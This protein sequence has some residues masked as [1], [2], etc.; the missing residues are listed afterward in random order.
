MQMQA[1]LELIDECRTRMFRYKRDANIWPVYHYHPEYDLLLFPKNTGQFILGDCIETVEP[2]SVIVNGPHLPHAF[3]AFEPDENDDERPACV[4]LQF[5]TKSLGQSFLD[6]EEMASTRVF[7]ERAR[8]GMKYTGEP[9]ERVAELMMEFEDLNDAQRLAQLLTIFD[10]LAHAPAADCRSLVSPGYSVGLT[11]R[12]VGKIDIVTRYIHE[13]L[14][15]PIQ[16]E[17]VAALVHMSAAS[18]SRFFKRHTGRT[19]VQYLNEMRIGA[20]CREL[21]NTDKSVTEV[22]FDSGFSTLSNFNRRFRDIK[23]S[24]PSRFRQTYRKLR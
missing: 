20:A 4:V 6:R 13:N 12:S 3:H 16:Q 5:S 17:D 15:N 21:I 23:Q 19:Y 9:R 1:Q 18:F 10:I 24:T 8:L 7:L 11:E 22:A 14:G 2:G